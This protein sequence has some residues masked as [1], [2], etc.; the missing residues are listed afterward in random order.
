M[1]KAFI[2][3][4]LI[5][6]VTYGDTTDLF[7]LEAAGF[8]QYQDVYV[9][10]KL[11]KKASY[12][13]RF[14]DE[15]FSIV[16]S[17]LKRFNRPFTVLDIGAAQGYFSIRAAEAYPESVFVMLEGSNP[18]YPMISKQLA[19][20]CRLNQHLHNLIWL[21]KLIVPKD[22]GYLRSHER[23][24]VTLLL[25]IVHWFPND[26]KQIIDD[27]HAMSH[28][29]ILE[30]PPLEA[31]LPEEH[32]NLR[33]QIHEYV[34]KLATQTMR[35]VPRHTNPSLYTAYYIL[36]NKPKFVLDKRPLPG[37]SFVTYLMLQGAHPSPSELFGYLPKGGRVGDL[38]LQGRKFDSAN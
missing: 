3:L 31:S 28:V 19:S 6:Y 14:L 4:Y 8:E 33:K 15:R 36:E 38:I 20:I 24:D 1:R 25:N 17:I 13:E 30:V 26:W 32:Y 10:G 34:A 22:I 37:I 12:H 35:G 11:V 23:F 2:L 21:D 29:T 27:T 5:S 18:A 9:Q 16:D 7:D